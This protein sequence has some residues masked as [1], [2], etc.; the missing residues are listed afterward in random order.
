MKK[1]NEFQ[2][3][4]VLKVIWIKK[5][6]PKQPLKLFLNWGIV[7][8]VAIFVD[9]TANFQKIEKGLKNKISSLSSQSSLC[10]TTN[11]SSIVFLL[12]R[13]LTKSLTL[14]K[15]ELSVSFFSLYILM[16]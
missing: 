3:M 14:S 16:I 8:N 5:K 12:L 13:S 15:F 11:T 2:R 4:I 6:N 10:H 1:V 9:V 7:K